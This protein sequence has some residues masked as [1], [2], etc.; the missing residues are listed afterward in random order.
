MAK[1]NSTNLES[2]AHLLNDQLE[3]CFISPN[4]PDSNMEPAN[5][6]DAIANMSNAFWVI[7]KSI[8]SD[9]TAPASGPQSLFAAIVGIGNGLGAV[10]SALDRVA[11]AIYAQKE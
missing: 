8:R 11:D 4:V 1:S 3:R 9:T 2:A 6:V 5:L 7:A 10:A